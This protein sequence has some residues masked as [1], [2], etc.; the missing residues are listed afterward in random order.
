[1]GHGP[2]HLTPERVDEVGS[3]GQHWPQAYYPTNDYDTQLPWNNASPVP[4]HSFSAPATYGDLTFLEGEAFGADAWW[5]N[6]WSDNGA[7]GWQSAHS[8]PDLLCDPPLGLVPLPLRS[9][10]PGAYPSAT[11]YFRHPKTH[12]ETATREPDAKVKY[13]RPKA[14]KVYCQLCPEHPEGFRGEHELRRHIDNNH[15]LEGHVKKWVCIEPTDP[16]NIRSQ[17]LYALEKCK[18]CRSGKQYGAYYNAAAHLRRSHFKEKPT[19]PGKARSMEDKRRGKG[20]GDWPPMNELKHWMKEISVSLSSKLPAEDDALQSPRSD[21]EMMEIAGVSGMADHDVVPQAGFGYGK[22]TAENDVMGTYEQT[23][24][25]HKHYE[26]T[27]SGYASMSRHPPPPPPP[28]P[29]LPSPPA[30]PAHTRDD[31]SRQP[32]N[33]DQGCSPPAGQAPS[34]IGTSFTADTSTY[35]PT[36]E[37]SIAAVCND[38]YHNLR[39]TVRLGTEEGLTKRLPA[40]IKAFALRIGRCTSESMS[41]QVM[42]TVYRHYR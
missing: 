37:A 13:V 28:P 24:L 40:L 9:A 36:T 23:V 6:S 42:C 10:T 15:S 25:A 33:D 2:D 32:R 30:R 4:D 8:A 26:P 38:I 17:P 31:P 7:T 35:S 18:A 34:I 5:S 11:E 3:Y 41:G 39:Q 16:Q 19:R 20:G 27:D 21:G 22:D 1:M 14:L 12:K 29:P